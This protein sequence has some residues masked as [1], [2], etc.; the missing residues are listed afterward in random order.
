MYEHGRF[1]PFYSIKLTYETQFYALTLVHSVVGL[2]FF[3]QSI[4]HDVGSRVSSR[5][6]VRPV[7]LLQL[8]LRVYTDVSLYFLTFR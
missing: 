7:S 6:N 4:L 2:E 3:H 8:R 1:A 5:P